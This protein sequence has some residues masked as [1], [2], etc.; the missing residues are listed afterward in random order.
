MSRNQFRTN[1]PVSMQHFVINRSVPAA[2]QLSMSGRLMSGRLN[3][4]APRAPR[5]TFCL[6]FTA[7]RLA[8]PRSTLLSAGL[9]PPLN[10][11]I[12]EVVPERLAKSSMEHRNI[13]KDG[14]VKGP[15][16]GRVPRLESRSV[17]TYVGRVT[18]ALIEGQSWRCQGLH[19]EA[20]LPYGSLDVERLAA[21]WPSNASK[22]A[23][24][25]LPPCREDECT[26]C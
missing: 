16:R 18:A 9:V 23:S 11:R 15:M 6:N 25:L 26:D 20:F 21:A 3:P 8:A 19:N 13:S 2:L 24:T 5:A 22:K 7:D 4:N 17:R 1:V 12:E 14:T 10:Q